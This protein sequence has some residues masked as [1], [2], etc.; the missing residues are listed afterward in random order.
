[1]I[2]VI[3]MIII[4]IINNNYDNYNENGN[5]ND[6]YSDNDNNNNNINKNNNTKIN[7]Y[8]NDIIIIIIT[9]RMYNTN[10][11][12]CKFLK[13]KIHNYNCPFNTLCQLQ[14]FLW[15]HTEYLKQK[16]EMETWG[17]YLGRAYDMYTEY[18][19]MNIQSSKYYWLSILWQTAVQIH[20]Y[21]I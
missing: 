19:N 11:K 15:Q 20:D 18:E 13:Y 5:N 21:E 12:K 7:D 8:N 3:K 6:N 17:I 14:A 10:G 2:I 9:I 1:M 16:T 4:I